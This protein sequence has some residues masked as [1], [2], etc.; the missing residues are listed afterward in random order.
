MI[1]ASVQISHLRLETAVF[2]WQLLCIFLLLVACWE[3]SAR[4]FTRPASR[5]AGVALVAVLLTL[6]IAGTALY[7]M[8]Q[9][10][11]PRN[12]VAFAAIFAIVAVI[13]RKYVSAGLA[14][15]VASAIHPLMSVF[16]FSFCILLLVMRKR[17]VSFFA[18][19]F[20]PFGISLAPP[21]KVYHQ[22]AISHS[23][24]YVTQWHWYEWLGV[25]GSL[26]VLLW[27]ARLGLKQKWPNVVLLCR[28][29]VVYELIYLIAA[30]LISIPPRFEAL[31]RLQPMRSLYLVYVL[32][33]VLGGGVLA[34]FVLQNRLWKWLMLFVPLGL[35]MFFAQRTLFPADAHIEWPWS[36]P[37][38]Q[39]VQAFLWIRDNT[40]KDSIFALD[41]EYLDISGEDEQGFRAIA[42]RSS[43][44]D[45][46]KDSGAV[47]MF[48]PM[49][50]E[51]W[52]QVQ[53]Q[54]GWRGFRL[55]DFRRLQADYGVN[56]LVL[57]RPGIE[58]L[59]CPYTNSAVAVCRLQ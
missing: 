33:L 14:L 20:F 45:T 4:C 11:N 26:L 44:A 43:L 16:A 22:V 55:Q 3:L 15:I 35:G 53:A 24:F 17:S 51:W 41:P 46:V 27:F 21:P 59:E 19:L 23:Y 9:Y 10:L 7:I 58:S 34:E 48:P 2:F 36:Q 56:W 37:K 32:M 50:D 25:I 12:L 38:N 28:T 6:P 18:L 57:Q 29:L 8:D 49:A 13:D 5:R 39:W 52:R 47:S 30:I 40:P 42:L 31:A 54:S 1:A